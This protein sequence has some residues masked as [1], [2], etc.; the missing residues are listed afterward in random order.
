MR[1]LRAVLIMMAIVVAS[2]VSQR[3]ATADEMEVLTETL[4]AAELSFA[5]SVAENDFES[6]KAH[7]DDQAVF[8]AA[9]VLN[10][11]AAI[12]EAWSG[13]FGENAPKMEWHPET[14]VVRASGGLGFSQG[15]YTLTLTNP[16]G[17]KTVQ[18]GSFTSIWEHQSDGGWKI[19][20]DSGCPPCPEC[21]SP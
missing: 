2:G 19:I 15:P 8:I 13:F 21:A 6:F 16:D 1:L 9:Q 10:G 11:K 14:V 7:I 3:H 4:R 17:T 20:F 12:A 18:K 5:A